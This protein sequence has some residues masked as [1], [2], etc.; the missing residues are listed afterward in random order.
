VE[1]EAVGCLGREATEA[2]NRRP[3]FCRTGL[4]RDGNAHG[5]RRHR[6]RGSGNGQTEK[7]ENQ[8]ERAK[9]DKAKIIFRAGF[10]EASAA[11]GKQ[12]KAIRFF[13]AGSSE[14]GEANDSRDG[15]GVTARSHTRTRYQGMSPPRSELGSS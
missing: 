3:N 12:N 14:A 4:A 9:H 13:S 2:G 7:R 5:T 8:K 15:P 11:A 10:V 1:K 6:Q